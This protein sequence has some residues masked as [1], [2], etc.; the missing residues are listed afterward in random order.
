MTRLCAVLGAGVV[1]L[2]STQAAA[3]IE[4]QA[5]LNQQHLWSQLPT[6]AQ[7]EHTSLTTKAQRVTTALTY[8]LE[9]VAGTQP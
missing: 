6:A 2:F 8:R 4:S 7:P 3:S 9:K 1:T 5:L